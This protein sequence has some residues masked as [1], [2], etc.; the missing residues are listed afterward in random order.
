MRRAIP[1]L[2]AVTAALLSAVACT[3]QGEK[4]DARSE[5]ASEFPSASATDTLSATN[6][7]LDASDSRTSAMLNSSSS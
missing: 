4:N 5:F 7:S 2:I 3:Q 1:A 6:V